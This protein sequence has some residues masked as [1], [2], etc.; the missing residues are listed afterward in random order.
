MTKESVHMF[1]K[2]LY[3]NYLGVE[4]LQGYVLLSFAHKNFNDLKSLHFTESS[5]S[6]S[7]MQIF[8]ITKPLHLKFTVTGNKVKVAN[9]TMKSKVSKVER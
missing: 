2:G 7:K 4:G 6:S 8:H 1:S 5:G 9:G 3:E